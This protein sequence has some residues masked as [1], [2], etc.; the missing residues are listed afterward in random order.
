MYGTPKPTAAPGNT[1]TIATVFEWATSKE[2]DVRTSR[3]A[4]P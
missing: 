4:M 3:G 1:R 2:P